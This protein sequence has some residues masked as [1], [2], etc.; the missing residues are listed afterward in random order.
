MAYPFPRDDSGGRAVRLLIVMWDFSRADAVCTCLYSC[1]EQVEAVC[2]GNAAQ[3]ILQLRAE[4]YDLL[5]LG[6][7]DGEDRAHRGFAV[8]VCYWKSHI[9]TFATA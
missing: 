1:L 3:A 6:L 7:G 2:C 4:E 9:V 8:F 5:L